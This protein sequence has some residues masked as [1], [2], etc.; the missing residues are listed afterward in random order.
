MLIH[1]FQSE[2][3]CFSR[4]DKKFGVSLFLFQQRPLD[5][6]FG[7]VENLKRRNRRC[8]MNEKGNRSIDQSSGESQE[9]V[10]T[11]NWSQ[12]SLLS[13]KL[14]PWYNTWPRR[15]EGSIKHPPKSI[16]DPT[17]LRH[18]LFAQWNVILTQLNTLSDG[19]WISFE[20][21]S[22]WRRWERWPTNEV[23]CTLHRRFRRM[24]IKLSPNFRRDYVFRHSFVTWCSMNQINSLKRHSTSAK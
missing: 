5:L 21:N 13:N 15:R 22:K 18:G 1:S 11:S 12:R 16:D 2:F 14:N 23:Q 7:A 17:Y 6:L 10:P 24:S 3:F 4:K 9:A 8:K 20:N 19:I